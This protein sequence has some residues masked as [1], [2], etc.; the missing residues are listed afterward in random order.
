MSGDRDENDLTDQELRRMWE[1]GEPVEVLQ[2]R[3]Q[4][5]FI[6]RDSS[7]R[8]DRIKGKGCLWCGEP[9]VDVTLLRD[10]SLYLTC[11]SCGWGRYYR[12]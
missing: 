2:T 8:V 3:A 5:G 1:E 7:R 12:R 10:G 4:R 9:T 11:R 6:R